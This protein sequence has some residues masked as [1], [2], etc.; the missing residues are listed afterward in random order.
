MMATRA[1]LCWTLC[2]FLCCASVVSAADAPLD[3][4]MYRQ[5]RNGCG[6][7]SLA[8]V[9]HYWAQHYSL[10]EDMTPD[11]LDLYQDL[12]REEVKGIRL[13]DMREYAAT[14]GFDAFTLQGRREDLTENLAKGRPV[15]VGLR[16][17]P[18][19]ELHFAVVVGLGS[20]QV[21]LNDPAK[22]KPARMKR[23]RFEKRWS[24]GGN[25]LLLAAPAAYP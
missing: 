18:R 24:A 21:W 10:P 20:D 6:A 7:A 5:E 8:M 17:Q 1:P 12:Y 14:H 19:G 3:V 13:A 4:P 15:I 22:K 16:K 11:P 25:W 9:M 23:S 2:V